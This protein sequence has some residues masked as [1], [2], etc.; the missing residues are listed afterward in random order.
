MRVLNSK[1]EVKIINR[2]DKEKVILVGVKLENRYSSGFEDYMEELKGLAEA[3]GGKVV[4]SLIQPRK[5]LDYASYI[6]KGKV[7]E[8]KHLVEE[9]EP[10]A[11]IFD[12]ELS[13]IQLRN[14]EQGLETKIID[15]TMLILDIFAQRAK[16]REGKLQVELA[17]LQYRLPRLKGIGAQ[18]SRLGGGIGTRGAGEQKLELDRRYLRKR[19]Q[20]IKKQMEKLETTRELHRKQRQRSGIKT[21][22]LVGYTNAGKSM[23]FNALCTVAHKSCSGQVEADPRLFQT[24]DT[25]TRRLDLSRDQEVLI[26]DT[27]GFIQELPPA[28]VAAFRS[29]LEEAVDADLLLHVVDIADAQYLDKIA[30]VEEV[31]EE[32]GAEGENILTVFNKVDLLDQVPQENWK[33]AV[34]L[35]AKS[36]QGI[37]KLL[38]VIKH[39]LDS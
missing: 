34:Y 15:R 7:E 11:L 28:L 19:I 36:G 18:L 4:A 22:S 31:L 27:V 35:S 1:Q 37:D 3:A 10:D 24:L 26:T 33:G 6:G 17:L 5:K 30:V 23:L 12:R 25:T 9:L 16:S 38:T 32:L 20:E 13:S 8:L 21:V 29:T 14:L 39:R 2:D